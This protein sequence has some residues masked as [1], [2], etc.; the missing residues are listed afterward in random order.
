MFFQS[1]FKMHQIVK[2]LTDE[3]DAIPEGISNLNVF[4]FGGT[5]PVCGNI[6]QDGFELRNR[7]HPPFSLIAF[8]RFVENNNGTEIQID[9]KRPKSPDFLW[10]LILRRYQ[11][12]ERKIIEFLKEWI[13]ME[14]LTTFGEKSS[15]RPER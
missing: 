9:L 11:H 6:W 8:G 12:D 5:S 1:P 2:I 3:V 13:K 14:P 15:H 7:S 10:A 4:S